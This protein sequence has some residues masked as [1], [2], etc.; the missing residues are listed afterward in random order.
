MHNPSY[1][2]MQPEDGA[3][4]DGDAGRLSLCCPHLHHPNL[5]GR[6]QETL[7]GDGDSLVTI[8]G[9]NYLKLGPFQDIKLI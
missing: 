4:V 2:E 9:Q 3:L 1:T 5:Q 6:I 8:F 7:G